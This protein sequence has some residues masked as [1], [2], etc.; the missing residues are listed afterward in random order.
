MKIHLARALLGLVGCSLVTLATAAPAHADEAWTITSFHSEIAIGTDSMLT[1]QEDIHVD[2]GSL[3]KHGVFRTIPLRYRYDDSRDR[4]YLLHVISVTAGLRQLT[5]TTSVDSD[6]EV[7]KIG[8]PTFLVTGMNR[9]V[10]TY[11]VRGAM[12]SFSDHD[13]LSWNVDG[14]LWP[15][16]KQS[17]SATIAFPGTALEAAACYQGPTGSRDPCGHTNTSST[18]DFA[19]T[20]LLASGEQMTIVAGLRK[21]FVHV[22]PPLLEP[23]RRQFPADAF[24]I[25]PLTV[26]ASLA[27]FVA[28]VALVVWMWWLH[29]RD[30]A[31]IGHYYSG[32]DTRVHAAPL[33]D[34]DPVVVEF[35]PPQG[36]RPAQ[37]GLLLD[38]SADAKDVTASIV[39]LAVRGNLTISEVPGQKDW[40]F[41]WKG[42]EVTSLQQY[43]KTL[44]DGIFAGRQ[45]VK[46]SELRGSFAPSLR[47]V[48]SQIYSDAMARHLFT[49]RPDWARGGW[50]CLGV[51][52]IGLGFALTFLLGVAFGW[53]L[54]G[55]AVALAGGVLAGMHR[56][57]PQRSAAGRDLMQHALG[58]R[59]YMTTAEKYRQQ[60]AAKAD[61]FTQLLPYAIVFGCVTLWAK[62]FEGIDIAAGGGAGW[63]SGAGPFQA[64]VLASS[65]ET[66]N[67]NISS[68]IS[69]TPPSSGSSSGLGGGGFSGGGGGGG[70]G[71]SW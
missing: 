45:Q 54:I 44:L 23:R 65:L 37:L 17:V 26:G 68:A 5:Y 15:V 50:G 51:G 32:P 6:N 31:Y 2:F 59:L 27:V 60:F 49:T 53:G 20:R 13:E 24:D 42:G 36:M 8:D 55:F 19:T 70:G 57:M 4:Y 61:I 33:F 3:Q 41:T 43:E 48:E 52:I 28:G 29:G 11:T 30:R 22:P 56:A 64:A 1:V 10:I 71:G 14:A 58:F 16:P 18:I 40:L 39:D 12:N 38:E 35:G 63:Y 9:Y 34:H 21:G 7:I 62:A 69:Y 25:T 47:L 67:T 66:M 46:L